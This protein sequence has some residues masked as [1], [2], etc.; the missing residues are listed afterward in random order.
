MKVQRIAVVTFA[1]LASAFSAQAH[2]IDPGGKIK[3]A[4]PASDTVRMT[5]ISRAVDDSHYWAAQATRKQMLAL[6][7]QACERGAAVVTFVPPADQR[8]LPDE[9]EVVETPRS[10]RAGT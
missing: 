3:V 7:R 8:Y 9:R 2:Q 10:G 6:A 4:C 5:T 1:A